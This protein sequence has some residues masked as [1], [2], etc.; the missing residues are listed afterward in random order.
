MMHVAHRNRGLDKSGVSSIERVFLGGLICDPE[1][2]SKQFR[3]V[4]KPN[5]LNSVQ[6][7]VGS[8]K[9]GEIVDIDLDIWVVR[10]DVC[11]RLLRKITFL[12]FLQVGFGMHTRYKHNSP[13]TRT[14]IDD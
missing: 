7:S 9:C 1:L 13:Q 4:F 12:L 10:F 6:S 5:V 14:S 2:D 3:F 8:V 11:C